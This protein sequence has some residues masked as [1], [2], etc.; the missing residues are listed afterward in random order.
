MAN[1]LLLNYF[2][3]ARGNVHSALVRLAAW[4][5]GTS[6]ARQGVWAVAPNQAL[7]EEAHSGNHTSIETEHEAKR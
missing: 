1:Y 7:N 3:G 4:G 6:T 2:A 5:G